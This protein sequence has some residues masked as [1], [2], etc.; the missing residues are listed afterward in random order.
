MPAVI[1]AALSFMLAFL[2]FPQ[3]PLVG[4]T[5]ANSPV[6]FF[7]IVLEQV[8]IGLIIGFTTNFLLHFVIMAGEF[9]A[10][11]LGLMQGAMN[12]FVQFQSNLFSILLPI[13]L[14]VI[15][16]ASGSH[17]FF[18]RVI[19][20]SFQYIPMGSFVWD[21]RSFASILILLSASSFVVSFQFAAPIMGIIFLS[22]VALG[23]MNRV[24]PQM[25]VWIVGI[26]IKVVVGTLVIIYSLPLMVQ[27]FHANFEQLQRALLAILRTGAN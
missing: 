23:L 5:I 16:F 9:I 2:V 18:I 3:M 19:F 7:M 11:D 27:L 6:F 24:M 4:F 14:I 1:K 17:F 15:F 20:E 8:F 22:T 25:Q 13:I 10:R 12:P 26:P 21:T